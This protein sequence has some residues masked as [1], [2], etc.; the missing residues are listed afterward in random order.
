M[1]ITANQVTMA[2]IF[3]LPVPSCMLIY[4]NAVDW[5]IAFALFVILGA[6]DFVDGLMARKEG[7]TRLGSLIDPVADK[8][9][10]AAILLSMVALEI[11][12]P[13]VVSILLVRELL[14]TALRSSVAIRQE[15]VKT[16]TLG[17][18]KTIIQMGGLGTI[19]LTIVL[20]RGVFTVVCL[21]LSVPFLTVALFYY[22]KK[23]RKVPFW[24]IP[25]FCAFFFVG[26][27]GYF[28]SK[29]LTL[30]MQMGVIIT[31]TWVSA[32]DYL[33]GSYKL[34]RRTG[35][36]GGD[37]ARIAW[38]IVH[39]LMV[40][41][42]VAYYPIMVLPVLVSISLEFGLGGIDNI[43]VTEKRVFSS[44]PFLC[45][46][47]SGLI[48]ALY[49]NSHLLFNLAGNPLYVAIALAIVS[50]ILCGIF[51]GSHVALFKRTLL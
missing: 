46:A 4:G 20:P 27:L 15:Q 47:L 38:S 2:R 14:M 13:W 29:E 5:W 6:T 28:V 43:V 24:S 23:T 39:G 42:L 8:I 19:F 32:I 36:N 10:I 17:K 51:F 3:L 40:A 37:W 25:V 9:F 7:P 26:I 22:I 1:R 12:P 48:F 18:L 44:W 33:V 16:S 21:A 11:F 49:L 35:I 50:S 45:S 34:F 31:I 30:A 41:P